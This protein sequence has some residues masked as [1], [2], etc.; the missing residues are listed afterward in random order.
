MTNTSRQRPSS[1]RLLLIL[2]AVG[3]LAGGAL[4]YFTSDD[5]IALTVSVRFKH[6]PD[7]LIAL[8]TEVPVLEAL[9][10][11]PSGT[12]EEVKNSGL[13]YDVDLSAATPGP[14]LVK[15]FPDQIE[16]PRRVSVIRI[17]PSSF[18]VTI[19]NR[20]EKI[21]PVVP[22]LNEDPTPGYIISRV[23]ADPSLV[24]LSGPMSVLEA[25][26]AVRTT[27]INVG[28]L[29]ETTKKEVA[30]NL[31]HDP[32][33]QAIGTNLVNVEIVVE[34]KIVEKRLDMPVHVMAGNLK[35]VITPDRIELLLRGP[36]NTLKKLSQENGVQVY[37]DLAGLKPGTYVRPAT[38]E[39]PL[40]TT[41]VKAKPEVFT[42][43]VFE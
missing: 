18:A 31:N 35:Y 43:E 37:V 14:L 24:Q 39:P 25:M 38:I 4:L 22:D 40:D 28:G 2:A 13:S 30:L 16:V 17:E 26:S 3:L 42:V 20:M 10:E 6:V 29:T 34:Q 8:H 23:V 27:P 9:L 15:I 11:G 12:L 21:V 1:K 36:V 41:L 19:D 33:V 7:D 5:E 32:H